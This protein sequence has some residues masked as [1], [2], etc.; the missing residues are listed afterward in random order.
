MSKLAVKMEVH[1][2]I[3]LA[4]GIA[5]EGVIYHHLPGRQYPWHVRPKG[6][7]KKRAGIAFAENELEPISERKPGGQRA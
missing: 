1:I 5:S 7:D 6:W 3:P 2:K 4:D